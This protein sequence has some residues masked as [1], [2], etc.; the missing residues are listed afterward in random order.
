MQKLKKYSLFFAV[1]GAGY[2]VLELLWRGRTHWSMVVAGG[3]CFAM[4]SIVAE[5]LKGLGLL[6]KALL[7]ALGITAVEFVF[8]IVFNMLL[9]MNVWDYSNMPFNFMGQ[10]CPYFSFLWCLLALCFLPLAEFIN[11]KLEIT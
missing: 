8:G 1:G 9:G 2:A 10:I 7:C 11:N 3:L 4:F 5:R 6:P